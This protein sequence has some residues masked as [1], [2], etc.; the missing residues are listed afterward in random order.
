M[1]D[2]KAL[3][4]A[5]R[6]IEEAEKAVLGLGQEPNPDEVLRTRLVQQLR[7]ALEDYFALISGQPRKRA[8]KDFSN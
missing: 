7:E 6:R 1:P 5:K 4:E 2:T 8:A 3:A